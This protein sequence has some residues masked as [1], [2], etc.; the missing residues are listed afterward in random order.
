[1]YCLN[2]AVVVKYATLTGLRP[3]EA[4]ESVRLLNPNQ[5]SDQ[6]YYNPETQTLEHFRFPRYFC[7]GQKRRIFPTSRRNNFLG[8]RF[9][10]V[11]PSPPLIQP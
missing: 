6:G 5:N 9:W 7:V 1:M 10:A 4:C 8:L 2:A 3:T 11:K